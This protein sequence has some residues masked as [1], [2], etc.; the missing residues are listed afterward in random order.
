MDEIDQDLA[1]QRYI[2]HT[3]ACT[4]L[5]TSSCA[6]VLKGNVCPESVTA[7]NGCPNHVASPL[8]LRGN[9]RGDVKP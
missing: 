4:I 2:E 6:C 9:I 5:K 8:V 7:C 1:S 3:R